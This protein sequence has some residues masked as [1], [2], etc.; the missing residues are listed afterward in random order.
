MTA[1]AVRI[2]CLVDP[3]H[4]RKEIHRGLEF[5]EGLAHPGGGIRYEPDS[6]YVNVCSTIFSLQ[7]HWMARKGGNPDWLL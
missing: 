4:Y 7:A 3:V 5:L 1:Q 2:W 6:P